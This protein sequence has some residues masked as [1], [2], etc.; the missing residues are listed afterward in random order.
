MDKEAVE[1]NID[2]LFED[3][4]AGPGETGEDMEESGQLCNVRLEG[5]LP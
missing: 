4:I 1:V 5:R 2:A 3:G